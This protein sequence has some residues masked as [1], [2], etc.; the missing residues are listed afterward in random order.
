MVGHLVSGSRDEVKAG[1]GED[2]EAEVAAAFG[3]FVGLFGEDRADATEPLKPRRHI[4]NRKHSVELTSS[5]KPCQLLD[6][7][8]DEHM[9]QQAQQD[10]SHK[11]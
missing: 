5:K 9:D 2:V 3:P 8:Q 4:A 6:A 11:H 7:R 1:F 10:S